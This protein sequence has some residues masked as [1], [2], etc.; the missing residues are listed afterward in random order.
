M[1]LPAL[2]FNTRREVRVCLIIPT[3]SRL[4]QR[5]W[6]RDMFAKLSSS[7]GIAIITSSSLTLPWRRAARKFSAKRIDGKALANDIIAEIQ[8]D[9]AN[10]VAKLGR[11][12]GL[13][14]VLVGSR[15]DST[16]YVKMKRK[17]AIEC[18]F[19][20]ATKLLDERVSQGELLDVV[21]KLNDDPTIDGI[22]V[23][24]PLPL[25]M[26]Q[27]NVLQAIDISKDVDGFHPQNMGSLLRIGE[28]I[29][30]RNDTF[31]FM[32]NAPCTPLGCLELISR[33]GIDLNSK[34]VVILGRSNIVGLPA[35]IMCLHKNATVTMCHSR[36]KN[37][38]DECL[39]ADV[40]I[41]AIGQPEF[42]KGDWVKSG[43]CVIDVGINFKDDP[44]RKSGERMCGDVDYVAAR[45]AL[46]PNGSI[47]P[48]PGGVGPMTVAMLMK[49]T[50]INAA[51][52]CEEQ[53][54][55]Q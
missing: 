9:V 45:E 19:K 17:R 29:R 5:S 40:I 44:S 26:D 53:E 10:I 37:I 6:A 36:T 35:A 47:T 20:S 48:V 30:Q 33:A 7:H 15:K 2:F 34:H 25:H 8:G 12:P 49:N 1:F 43:A 46:G 31:E 23:Q 38:R 4:C 13:A 28:T 22:L 11:P 41:T 50:M 52:K 21:T 27:K 42:V 24:L 32:A 3:A 51:R 54:A 39:R 16:T 14:M 18:G 55:E